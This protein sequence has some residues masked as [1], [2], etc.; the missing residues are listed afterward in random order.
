MSSVII[1]KIMSVCALVATFLF[2]A[3]QM[4]CAENLKLP[5]AK[6]ESFIVV[7]GYDSPPTHVNKDEYAIDFSQNGCD[8]YAKPALAASTGRVILAEDDGYN[9]GYGTEILIDGGGNGIE[10]YAHLISESLDVSLGEV[11]PQGMVLGAIGNTGLVAGNA[12]P[13]HPGTHIHFATYLKNSDGTYSA[14]L[15]EP[16]S[17]Y[18]GITEGKWYL[19]DN[20]AALSGAA[21]L[22]AAAAPNSNETAIAAQIVQN[23]KPVPVPQLVTPSINSGTIGIGD[24][25]SSA[26]SLAY[27]SGSSPS[28]FPS[29]IPV[30]TLDSSSPATITSFSLP[31]SSNLS[32]SLAAQNTSLSASSALPL[33]ASIPSG[34]VSVGSSNG[35]GAGQAANGE[36]ES[37]ENGQASSSLSAG[38]LPL[39]PN[40]PSLVSSAAF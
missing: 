31:S 34:G 7:Q 35:G 1:A 12:C 4:V 32:S 18:I 10:R 9:G 40:N 16:I 11:V 28:S 37:G 19:S 6:G 29:S 26:A 23:S 24:G 5:Y 25:G 36:Q 20:A 3:A 14:L 27:Q 30:L 21:G 39:A 22:S 17:N 8:A 33:S 2:G 15:P 13:Q 38:N